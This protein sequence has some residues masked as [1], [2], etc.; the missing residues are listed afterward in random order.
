[1]LAIFMI[2]CS[3]THKGTVPSV[4]YSQYSTYAFGSSSVVSRENPLIQWPQFSQRI[5]K[6]LR[7][8]L[9]TAGLDPV[10]V[11]SAPDLRI[12]YYIISDADAQKPVVDYEI[13]WR[14]EPFITQGESFTEYDKNTLVLD[15]VDV[16]TNELVWRGSTSLPLDNEKKVY[17]QLS[18]K[19]QLLIKKYPYFPS[20]R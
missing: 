14:A 4:N 8:H 18:K 16:T 20:E 9:P 6:A 10:P 3:S 12:Y 2:A 19:I 17:Q 7:F 13:G 11:N 15:F 5:E 1:M